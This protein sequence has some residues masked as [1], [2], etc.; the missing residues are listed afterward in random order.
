MVDFSY[1]LIA[2]ELSHQW[3]GNMITCG[4]WH[5]VWLNEGFATYAT[6]LYQ[7]EYYPT[8]WESWKNSTISN[9]VGS[10]KGSVYCVDTT[11]DVQLYNKR[12]IY[13][14]GALV[15]HQLRWVI[16]DE[17]FFQTMWNYTHD[18]I[19]R[20]GS[21][22]TPDFI[23][24]AEVASGKDL[25]D[26]FDTWFY[27]EG[28][29]TYTFNVEQTDPQHATLILSQKPSHESVTCFNMS[30]PILFSGA[31]RDTLM[32]F[33]NNALEQNFSFSPGFTIKTV[34]FDP[35]K[36]LICKYK[37]LF[38]GIDEKDNDYF[39]NV[40]P[41]PFK[42]L[43]GVKF[44]LPEKATWTLSDMSGKIVKTGALSTH[45]GES[46]IALPDLEQGMYFIRFYSGHQVI[47]RKVL[48]K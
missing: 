25:T 47:T 13:N 45:E 34:T 33:D 31:E 15:L 8:A 18:S 46:N 38:V 7:E 21:A 6:A 35:D 5:D 26:F 43:V 17:A 3:F 4:S 30:V 20:Y 12:L 29:P 22:V 36:W 40:F 1:D 39:L 11:S 37:S 48:C 10:S 14:K 27:G 16:G 42:N 28:Y 24:H 44:R 2:H 41:N 19:L 32:I 9:V 23:A